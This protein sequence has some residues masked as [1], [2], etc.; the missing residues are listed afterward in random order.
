M[1]SDYGSSGTP[2]GEHGGSSGNKQECGG[3]LVR[4]LEAMQPSAAVG[5]RE[6]K[7]C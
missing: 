3:E 1:A 2:P 4:R 5:I 6:K 7:R